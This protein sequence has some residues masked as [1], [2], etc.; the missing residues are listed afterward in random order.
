MHEAFLNDMHI[1]T[2]GLR[3]SVANALALA[4]LNI[5]RGAVAAPYITTVRKHDDV[6]L[7]FPSTT[8]LVM[9]LD[10]VPAHIAA[11]VLEEGLEQY[12]YVRA[13]VVPIPL[14]TNADQ[15]Q[16]FRMGKVGVHQLTCEQSSSN[17]TY[18][19]ARLAECA[20]TDI[21]RLWRSELRTV[22]GDSERG[23]VAMR[24]AD[25]CTAP[26]V[27]DLAERLYRDDSLTSDGKRRRLWKAC[28][29][30][31]L[32]NPEQLWSA[33]RLMLLKVLL[34]HGQWSVSRIAFHLGYDAPRNLTE[35]CKRRY[36]LT[37]TELRDKPYADVRQ[38]VEDLMK[39]RAA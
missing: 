30:V 4:V 19:Q 15:Y 34:D 9:D 21:L 26:T 1:V 33:V 12:P 8:V 20:G 24:I 39:E 14:Q 3:V 27:G 31:G 5:P 38:H 2:L 35:A 36:G 37:P 18:W 16:L 28:K 22:F 11:T 25:E 17:A 32:A 29:H 23:R 13:Y 6:S 10:T 7:A